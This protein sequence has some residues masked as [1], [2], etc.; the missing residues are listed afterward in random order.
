[1]ILL[2]AIPGSASGSVTLRLWG[3]GNYGIPPK[4]ATDSWSQAQRTV[5]ERFQELHPEINVISANGLRID[6]GN[7]AFDSDFLLAMAGGSA[8]DII[9]VNFRQLGSY[10]NQDFL[11][12]LNEYV[13]KTPGILRNVNPSIRRV[14]NIDGKI[15]CVPWGQFAMALY[16][17]KDLYRDSGLDPDK[18]PRTWDEFY[19]YCKKLTIPEKGQ[20]GFGF[21]AYPQGTPYHWVNF[22]W[23]AGGQVVTKDK[24]GNW[25]ASFN[26]PGGVRALDFYKKL[27]AGEWTLPNGAL[28]RGVASRT[29]SWEDDKVQGK[30][31]QW[32]SDTSDTVCRNPMVDPS[33]LGVAELPAGPAGKA[34]AINAAM[35][36]M[37]S[38]IKDK[39]VRDAAWEFI[40]FMASD[41]ADRIRVKAYVEAGLS[42]LVNPAKL[43]QYGYT[44]YLR[45]FRKGWAEEIQDAFKHGE[46]EP[47][48]K[49][50]ELLYTEMDYP[51]EA[52]TLNPNSDSRALLDSCVSKINTKMLGYVPEGQMQ[53]KRRIAWSVFA[54]LLA[55]IGSLLAFQI[56]KLLRAHPEESE[57]SGT[58]RGGMR[59]H[60]IAWLFMIPAVVSVLAWSY[61]P[62][63]RG[64]IM[65]FQNYKIL[66]GSNFVGLDNFISVVGQDTFWIGIVNSVVYTALSLTLGF[67][68]P[69]F[70]ALMLSEIP[71]G[72]IAYRT[73]YYLPAVTSGL[74]I[75]F[76]WKWFYDPT[77]MGL[78]NSMIGYYNSLAIGLATHIHPALA[79]LKLSTQTW[80]ADPKLAMLCVVL[81]TI[82]A[83]AGPG[84]IIYL[85][86]MKGIP[87]EMYEAA[88]L[89]GAG[90]WTK[91]WR[92][93]LPSLMPLL[94]INF[95]GAF[96]GSFKAMENIFVL[97]G[98]GPLY[99][100]HTIGL[101]IWYNAF[102]Y[103]R[104]GYATAAAWIMG[105]MLV[106]FTMYQLRILKDVRFSTTGREEG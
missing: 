16:Y 47:Y 41:E 23:Q 19:D 18:P 26:S 97:T 65:A 106:G 27:L 24:H 103:L 42:K 43:Q 35:W 40:K 10:V 53:H 46:P 14:L 86:A 11:Y 1:M 57:G 3:G 71:R 12:P 100:T 15:Y 50:C 36:G 61:Y 37:N 34:C 9:Y 90:V 33:L 45:G 63:L 38:Q 99:R 79:H 69:V 39:R 85:A 56:R 70:L 29:N 7:P 98:G 105:S 73:V 48:G 82:W 49:N 62:L 88:D 58:V 25:F 81:P 92:I 51:I 52:S 96:I 64:M 95:V 93:T 87:E 77:P 30:I 66:G 20:Y 8:P 75:I 78:F 67:L 55:G 4:D 72:K 6:S 84:S 59:V 102:L 80:L 83:G 89:D 94:I 13:D 44:E 104:F 2:C 101:E 54:V 21:A 22:I 28:F 60:V 32:I 17:R 68:V 31:A 91:V 74:V 76:L 5:F